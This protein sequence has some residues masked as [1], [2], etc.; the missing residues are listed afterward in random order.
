MARHALLA[1]VAQARRV[2]HARP[3]RIGV[4]PGHPAGRGKI[5]V[6]PGRPVGPRK[7][8]PT[9]PTPGL[10]APAAPA[11]K[12]W[13]A[14]A[15]E[16]WGAGEQSYNDRLAELEGGWQSREE[17]Y[18]LGATKNPYSQA[19]LLE[20]RHEI[21]RRGNLN[22]AGNQ[23]YAGSL[24]NA[25]A[26]AD[27]NYNEGFESLRAAYAAEQE[28]NERQKEQARHEREAEEGATNREAIERAEEVEPPPTP[29]PE[30]AGG[31]NKKGKAKKGKGGGG[32]GVAPAKPAGKGKGK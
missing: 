19:A 10:A 25:M 12:P 5:G 14:Q 20:R 7:P 22:S 27:R 17:W 18:G 3:T 13:D 16:Q 2:P 21:A 8:P 32:P 15:E 4:G 28:Q 11:V 26:G 31:G 30:G 1:R 6:S 29:G 24:V 23:L 9:P